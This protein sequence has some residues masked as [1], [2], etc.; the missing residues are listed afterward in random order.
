MVTTWTISITKFESFW[1]GVVSSWFVQ[2][3][4]ELITQIRKMQAV[5]KFRGRYDICFRDAAGHL[6][7]TGGVVELRY[8][9]GNRFRT[10]TQQKDPE[11]DWE[12]VLRL[13]KFGEH[14]TGRGTYSYLHRDDTGIHR[15]I[16]SP[17]THCFNVSVENTSH[18]E[19]LKDT[20]I[21]WRPQLS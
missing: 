10:R 19:G 2:L 21:V 14:I 7:P 3:A 9:I 15:V 1:I 13:E 17:K 11:R 5:R 4:W 8:R 18:P 16:L 12:G 20:K 6:E